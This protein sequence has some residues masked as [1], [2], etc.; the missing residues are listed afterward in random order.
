MEADGSNPQRLVVTGG[1]EAW[2]QERL[3]VRGK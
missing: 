2:G 1:S 3:V